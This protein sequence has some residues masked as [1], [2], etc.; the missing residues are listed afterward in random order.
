MYLSAT[1]HSVC[2]QAGKIGAKAPES[3]FS[4]DFLPKDFA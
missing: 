1:C 4:G 2:P 3:E